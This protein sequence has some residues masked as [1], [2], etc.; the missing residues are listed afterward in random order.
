MGDDGDWMRRP[1]R[2]PEDT[3]AARTEWERRRYPNAC[4]KPIATP[5][6]A[7]MIPTRAAPKASNAR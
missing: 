7:I 4:S 2:A 3:G 1:E 5:A 6:T